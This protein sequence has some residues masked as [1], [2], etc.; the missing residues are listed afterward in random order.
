M[1]QHLAGILTS[2]DPSR[3]F[4]GSCQ[5]P[6]SWFNILLGSLLLR[7]LQ[8]SL[9]DPARILAHDFGSYKDLCLSGSWKDICRILPGSWFM[10]R[11]LAGILTSK[12]P[13]RIFAGSC[14]DPGSWLWILQGSLPFR[15]LEGYLQD[16]ARILPG[17]WFMIRH[18]A[19]ILTPRILQ[20]SCQDPGSCLRILQGS[21]PCRI[22][23]GS[24]QVPERIL[25]G[26]C[27]CRIPAGSL[28]ILEDPQG[29]CK[30]SHQGKAQCVFCT[31]QIAKLQHRFIP[32]MNG[33]PRQNGNIVLFLTRRTFLSVYDQIHWIWCFGNR[34]KEFSFQDWLVRPPW[35]AKPRFV[36]RLPQRRGGARRLFPFSRIVRWSSRKESTPSCILILKYNWN[37]C[38]CFF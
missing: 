15:I 13:S 33:F 20:G 27:P 26:S 14:Q 38:V 11:H 36:T 12:D 8:G 19:G 1:I 21:L 22:L 23:V 4:A 2:K 31:S 18:P 6:G 17:S 30:D 25:K 32:K 5:D 10:I 28:R 16:P 24:L 3:I 9:Q 29:S 34:G 7:I 35:M 37:V